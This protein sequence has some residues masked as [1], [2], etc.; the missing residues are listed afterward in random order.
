MAREFGDAP[1]DVTAEEVLGNIDAMLW[2]LGTPPSTAISVEYILEVHRRLLAGTRLEEQGGRLRSEQNWIGGSSLNPCSAAFVP[3]P[4]E[5]V[6]GLLDDLCFFS[7]GDSLPAVVQAAVAHAQF[8]T[9]HPFADGNG[10]TGR[11]LIHLIL[12]RRGLTPRILPPISLVLATRAN[13]Y[14]NALMGTRYAGSPAS[15]VAHEGINHWIGLFA[16]ACKRAVEDAFA[17]EES[18]RDL[19][20]QWRGRLGRVRGRSALDL[21]LRALPG[22]PIVT[23]SGAADLIGRSFQAANKAVARL[24]AAGIVT[25]VNIGR[26][27]RAFEAIEVMEAFTDLERRLASPAVNMR[28][29]PP[30]RAVPRRPGR[31]PRSALSDR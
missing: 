1:R 29:S 20:E 24:V 28:V 11:A 26:R 14:V 12:R 17:F 21:L 9:I 16:A 18:V 15:K 25:Q 7:N 6:P 2:A 3:P 31:P 23:A 22:A 13:D 5:F 10:R 30:A 4:P 27:N 8:E 19:Q